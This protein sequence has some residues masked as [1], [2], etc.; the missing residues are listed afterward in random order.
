MR[1]TSSHSSSHSRRTPK[2]SFFFFFAVEEEEEGWKLL[3]RLLSSRRF[4][5]VWCV[6]IYKPPIT[7]HILLF[8]SCHQNTNLCSSCGPFDWLPAATTADDELAR[9]LQGALSVINSSQGRSGKTRR[10]PFCL[11]PSSLFDQHFSFRILSQRIWKLFLF[12][13]QKILANLP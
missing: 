1:V 6:H 5:N 2:N 10:T 3:F 13:G 11:V 9:P 4:L 12:N 8:F 7:F